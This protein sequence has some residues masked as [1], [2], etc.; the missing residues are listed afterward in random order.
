MEDGAEAGVAGELTTMGQGD[1]P[2]MSG[3]E[4]GHA[5]WEKGRDRVAM[6]LIL[7]GFE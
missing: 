3:E 6:P 2:K 7:G 1:R 5:N 4:E